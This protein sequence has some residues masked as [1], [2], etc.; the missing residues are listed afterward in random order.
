[1]LRTGVDL[2]EVKRI[3]EMIAR[4]GDRFLKRVF[5]Q[6][7]L[8]Y[9]AGR[10]HSLAARFAAKEA[11]SKL[12]AVGIQHRDGVD[13]REIEVLSGERGDPVLNLYGRA[14]ARSAEL[15]FNEI[16]LSLS[17][18]REHAIAFVVGQG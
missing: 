13:W 11:V 7:E 1:L 12:L 6:V 4:Y 16:A 15:G 18:T 8:D 9:A 5:T 14:A 10:P 2:V 17:H 3:E